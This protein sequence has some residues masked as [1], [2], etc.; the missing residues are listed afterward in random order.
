[1]DEKVQEDKGEPLCD[2]HGKY[3]SSREGLWESPDVP[4]PVS[5]GE[6]SPWQRCPRNSRRA[7][8]WHTVLLT[9]ATLG[10]SEFPGPG[11]QPWAESHFLS[12]KSFGAG[13]REE[14]CISEG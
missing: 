11:K 3:P 9:L 2:G 10:N 5:A 12:E 4:A 1:M 14:P 8:A 7:A 13:S 6:S